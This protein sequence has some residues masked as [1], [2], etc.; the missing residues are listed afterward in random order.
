MAAHQSQT[1]ARN[2]DIST[3][4]QDTSFKVGTSEFAF[5][6]GG[7]G[8]HLLDHEYVFFSGDMNYRIDLPRP[9]VIDLISKNA[10]SELHVLH[11]FSYT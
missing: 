5:V 3:I 8:S 10:W 7:D 2:N 11:C 1:S 6:R 9:K 4:L